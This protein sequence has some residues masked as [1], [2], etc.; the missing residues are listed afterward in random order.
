MAHVHRNRLIKK[1]QVSYMVAVVVAYEYCVYVWFFV[2]YVCESEHPLAVESLYFG[3][4]PELEIAF[5]AVCSSWLKP[6]V[7][8][9]VSEV[10][11]LSE[12]KV[13]FNIA[14]A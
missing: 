10:K 4:E 1:A 14:V 12:V 8:V 13:C 5:K 11:W 6:F 7:E 2:G 3:K 9:I